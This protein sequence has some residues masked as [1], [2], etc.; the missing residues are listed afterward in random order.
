MRKSDIRLPAFDV[1]GVLFEFLVDLD[2]S[3]SPLVTVRMGDLGKS[4]CFSFRLSYSGLDMLAEVFLDYARSV[5][6]AYEC[7]EKTGTSKEI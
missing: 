6:E 5:G 7:W 1:E 4:C 3:D 2:S